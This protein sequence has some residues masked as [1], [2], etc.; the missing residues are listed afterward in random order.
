MPRTSLITPP[1]RPSPLALPHSAVPPRILTHVAR[2]GAAAPC[3]SVRARAAAARRPVAGTRP[4]RIVCFVPLVLF[5]RRC[6]SPASPRSLSPHPATMQRAAGLFSAAWQRVSRA[7]VS[8]AV[9][10]FASTA[11]PVVAETV[12]AETAAAAAP[13][14][15]W[16]AHKLRMMPETGRNRA[17]RLFDR[18]YQTQVRVAGVPLRIADTS[19]AM[20]RPERVRIADVWRQCERGEQSRRGRRVRAA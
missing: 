11:E 14:P 3:G 2:G 5:R 7:G 4:R 15:K 12:V 6:A 8:G 20:Q 9:R 19:L 13:L 1:P 16:P 17:R 18:E 10:S